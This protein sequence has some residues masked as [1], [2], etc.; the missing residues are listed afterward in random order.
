MVNMSFTIFR[1]FLK[2]FFPLLFLC[3]F[4]GFVFLLLFLISVATI[5]ISQLSQVNDRNFLLR[6]YSQK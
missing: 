2:F 4:C 6:P 3:F 5:N 1:P